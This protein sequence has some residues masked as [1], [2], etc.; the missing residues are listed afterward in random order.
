MDS[1]RAQAEARPQECVERTY[2]LV[3]GEPGCRVPNRIHENSEN[4]EE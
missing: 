4:R 3:L 1:G 2:E